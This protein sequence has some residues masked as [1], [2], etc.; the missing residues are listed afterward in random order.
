MKKLMLAFAATAATLVAIAPSAT[1]ST[2]TKFKAVG[3]VQS[4][5]KS[6]H[7]VIVRSKLT[8]P[9]GHARIGHAILKFRVA[10]TRSVNVTGTFVV[11]GGSLRVAGRFSGVDHQVSIVGGNHRWEGAYGVVRLHNGGPGA[12]KYRFSVHQ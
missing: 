5:T 12:E 6:G 3:Q 10:T 1:A 7:G 11:G 9:G 8:A 4:V 2:D